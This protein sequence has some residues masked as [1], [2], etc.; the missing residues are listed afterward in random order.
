MLGFTEVVLKPVITRIFKIG[1]QGYLV[2]AYA[3][4]DELLL[5]PDNWEH[6]VD[7][8]E[9]F[10]YKCVIPEELVEEDLELAEDLVA[11]IIDNFSL[12]TFLRKQ[13][14]EPAQLS[15]V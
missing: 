7:N 14:E 10:L 2:P 8:A 13:L 12:K 15:E 11:Y 3:K 6:F 1:I 9:E 5:M 4:L